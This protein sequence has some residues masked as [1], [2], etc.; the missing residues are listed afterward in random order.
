VP[1][2]PKGFGEG[3]ATMAEGS[4]KQKPYSIQS[5]TVSIDFC[6]TL[7]F[8]SGSGTDLSRAADWARLHARALRV[9]RAIDCVERLAQGRATRRATIVDR[10]N[11][12]AASCECYRAATDLLDR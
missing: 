9:S 3:W 6:K 12:E 11:L 7:P 4:E 8:H 1:L 5:N 2:T 10:E